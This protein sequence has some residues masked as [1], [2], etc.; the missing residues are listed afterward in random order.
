MEK[1]ITRA[2]VIIS[3]QSEQN[4]YWPGRAINHK[5]W[6]NIHPH[7]HASIFIETVQC[8]GMYGTALRSFRT[9]KNTCYIHLLCLVQYTFTLQIKSVHPILEPLPVRTLKHNQSYIFLVNDHST[10][11]KPPWTFPKMY[12][13]HIANSIWS[14]VGQR[15]KDGYRGAT[16]P[17]LPTVAEHRQCL[18]QQTVCHL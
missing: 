8:E 14:A 15:Q 10:L 6:S 1:C 9:S 18:Q 3:G 7:Q 13:H 12:Q 11:C 16:E 4:L 2:I 17:P 5:W